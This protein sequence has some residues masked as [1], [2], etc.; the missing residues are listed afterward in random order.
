MVIQVGDS[1]VYRFD[2]STVICEI[3]D[4]TCA[5]ILVLPERRRFLVCMRDR[6]E[7]LHGAYYDRTPQNITATL[8]ANALRDGFLQVDEEVA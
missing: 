2:G 5:E 8:I 1:R 7:R 6:V 3:Y 4:D